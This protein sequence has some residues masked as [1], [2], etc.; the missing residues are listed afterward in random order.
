MEE[1]IDVG[2]QQKC[3]YEQCECLVSSLETYC[4]EYCSNADGE[5]EVEVQCDC[6]HSPCTLD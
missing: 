5:Q 1:L 2:S 3:A 6:K 4:S